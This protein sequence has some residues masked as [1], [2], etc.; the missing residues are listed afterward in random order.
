MLTILSFYSVRGF[1]IAEGSMRKATTT[2]SFQIKQYSESAID[3]ASAVSGDAHYMRLA[4]RHAQFAFR[5]KEV[6]IGAVIVDDQGRVVAAGRNGVN[7]QNDA[8]AH[9]EIV[10]MRKA[11]KIL[12]N[13]R[14]NNCTLYTTLEP[15]LMCL[16]AA[17]GFR[18]NRIVYGAQD[19]R[20]GALGSWV[21]MQDNLHPFHQVQITSG[22]LQEESSALLKRFF[23]NRRREN[24]S[25]RNADLS[26]SAKVEDRGSQGDNGL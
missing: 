26:E 19:H 21:N 14:L 8:T 1:G 12:N 5:E 6:P 23:Q 16:G 3:S 24:E 10:T 25:A 13:W 17:Q 9:A 22:V 15:C 4:L 2:S 18:L 7:A 11:S 20:L